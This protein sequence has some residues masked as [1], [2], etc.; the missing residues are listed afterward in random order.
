MLHPDKTARDGTNLKTLTD[1]PRFVTSLLNVSRSEA[2]VS[3][4]SVLESVITQGCGRS[5]S[6][7]D[8]RTCKAQ[9]VELFFV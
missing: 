1:H 2:R 5:A 9:V 3:E 7:G 8:H 6:V 4:V